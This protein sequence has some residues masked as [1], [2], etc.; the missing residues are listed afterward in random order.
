[1]HEYMMESFC[2]AMSITYILLD[3]TPE[4]IVMLPFFFKIKFAIK[5]GFIQL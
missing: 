5:Q 3:N 4:N 2:T 1:M